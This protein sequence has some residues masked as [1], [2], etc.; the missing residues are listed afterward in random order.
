MQSLG[1]IPLILILFSGSP[2][3]AAG[4]A[5]KDRLNR[6]Y[7]Q[8]TQELLP[9]QTLPSLDRF[10][11]AALAYCKAKES[12]APE[13]NRT[14]RLAF[15][16]YS[17]SSARKRLY[18]FD[19]TARKLLSQSFATHAGASAGW[20][21]F[22]EEDATGTLPYSKRLI[23][24]EGH[25]DEA[26]FFSARPGSLESSLGLALADSIPYAS[27]LWGDPALRITGLDGLLNATLKGRGVVFHSFDYSE[28]QV[29]R[30]GLAPLSEGC[31]MLPGI[32]ET[33]K[34]IQDL[35]G[36]LV[37]LFH[38]RLTSPELNQNLL[39][40]DR[41]TYEKLRQSLRPRLEAMATDLGWDPATLQAKINFYETKLK[42]N[43]LDRATETFELSRQG[44]KFIHVSLK[45][46][47][48]C[49]P[50]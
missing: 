17:E 2:A 24:H 50:D 26:R 36:A 30:M 49:F 11:I 33:R 7:H 4:P 21:R 12:R 44:S 10:R 27:P 5:L 15:V 6:L 39:D 31:L 3:H 47:E 1:F 25:L 37:L 20:I 34:W 23:L 48:R 38:E 28:E 18:L 29:Q 41:N 35:K 40:E 43:W 46:E 42:T 16:D 9:E 22:Y 32:D 14:T 19:Y 8:F 45:D 13:L